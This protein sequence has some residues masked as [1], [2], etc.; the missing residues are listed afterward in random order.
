MGEILTMSS[1][2]GTFEAL[3]EFLIS[4]NSLVYSEN[5]LK[6]KNEYIPVASIS[7]FFLIKTTSTKSEDLIEKL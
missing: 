3:L 2:V 5:Q 7:Y 1:F 6:M 4:E